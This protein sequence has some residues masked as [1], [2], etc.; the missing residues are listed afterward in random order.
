MLL[1]ELPKEKKGISRQT[2]FF[3]IISLLHSTRLWYQREVR[4]GGD[5]VCVCGE[6]SDCGLGNGPA[7]LTG[8]RAGHNGGNFVGN[9]L[10]EERRVGL[11]VGGDGLRRHGK[12]D[13]YL[14]PRL[15]LPQHR[16]HFVHNTR[17][18]ARLRP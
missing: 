11:A 4:K 3:F 6:S 18:H 13:F 7:A 14:H 12:H 5:S 1:N 16:L 15:A 8:G 10:T 9:L 2:F 17:D